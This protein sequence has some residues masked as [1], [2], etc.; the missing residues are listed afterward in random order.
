MSGI[1][2]IVYN[3]WKTME[4]CQMLAQRD[5][6]PAQGDVLQVTS[7]ANEEGETAVRT[8]IGPVSGNPCGTT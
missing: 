6:P 7:H 3:F 1:A 5:P 8:Q 4:I 2:M